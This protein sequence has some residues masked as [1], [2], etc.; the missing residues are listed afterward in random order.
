[1]GLRLSFRHQLENLLFVFVSHLT[2]FLWFVYGYK[3][4]NFLPYLFLSI[5][6]SSIHQHF[7]SEWQHE[8]THFNFL[9]NKKANDILANILIGLFFGISV[10][11]NRV[12]HFKHHKKGKFLNKDDF[13]SRYHI[14]KTKKQLI[15]KIIY[16]LVG[17][18]SLDH[19]ISFF[20]KNKKSKIVV[21][22]NIFTGKSWVLIL[23]FFHL[24]FLYGLLLN[25]RIEIYLIYYVTLLMIYPLFAMLRF[26]GQHAIIKGNKLAFAFESD[27]S[28]SNY[29]G[30]IEFLF[31]NTPL[32]K[33]HYEHHLYPQLPFRELIK[34]SK[35]NEDFNKNGNGCLNIA[36]MVWR[37]LR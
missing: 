13:E 16:S 17:I 32:M 24:P 19:F 28:R 15:K 10:N 37:A 9:N 12:S 3:Y 2:L 4:L 6:I 25:N 29:G 33:Y 1:M 8:A 27:A 7:L 22:N 31:F 36:I 14:V 5:F 23:C 20:I 11:A 35:K 34:I 26:W 30:L 18:T 21:K